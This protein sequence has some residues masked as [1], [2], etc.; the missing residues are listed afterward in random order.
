MRGET[1][2]VELVVQRRRILDLETARTLVKVLVE[3][4]PP[5]PSPDDA[6]TPPGYT[7]ERKLG[8]GAGGVVWLARRA[9]SDRPVALKILKRRLG[10][11]KSARRAWRE[12]ELLEQVRAPGTPRLVDYGTI[13]DRFYITAEHVDGISIDAYCEQKSLGT[14]ERVELLARLCEAAAGLHDA[15]VI[16]RDLKPSNVLVT[17]AGVPVIIDLGIA[18]L[19]A[20]DVMETLTADGAPIGTPAFMAPEQAR[21]ERS[22]IGIRS[23]VWS[24]GAIGYLLLTG[25]TP[26]DL[27]DTTL[28]EAVRRVGDEPPSEPL[29]IEPALPKPLG[30]VLSKACAP[31]SKARY[32]SAG[33]LAADLRRWLEHEPVEAQVAGAWV[34]TTRWI[35]RHPILSTGSVCLA[36]VASTALGIWGTV[37][38]YTLQ[39]FT[40]ETDGAGTTAWIASRSGR[41]LTT[42]VS[43]ASRGVKA[44]RIPLG[45]TE[46]RWAALL[47]APGERGLA[48]DAL[49][50]IDPWHPE[51]SVWT[52][53]DPGPYPP[54]Q[55]IAYESPIDRENHAYTIKTIFVADVFSE[56]D[57]LEFVCLN[58]GHPNF[59]SCIRVFGITTDWR[60][61]ELW[62]AWL[63][64]HLDARW[65]DSAGVFIV[66][67]SH[68]RLDFLTAENSGS[69]V[70]THHAQ[71]VMTLEPKLGYISDRWI[72][73]PGGA[74]S[75]AVG[76][77]IVLEQPLTGQTREATNDDTMVYLR[78]QTPPS[79]RST[80]TQCRIVMTGM[81]GG[82]DYGTIASVYVDGQLNQLGGLARTD[83]AS[84]DPRFQQILGRVEFAE[85]PFFDPNP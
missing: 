15:G 28:Y 66:A 50:I 55:T 11:G 59:P 24:L 21:G 47:V 78:P 33:E 36:I 7:L 25:R 51:E 45:W 80:D 19:L 22:A 18:S 37:R 52:C 16:H 70:S 67:G 82:R 65:L 63:P 38:H 32:G 46:A 85:A 69:A 84:L 4:T 20:S 31:A 6:T 9:G 77:C 60:V 41:P 62:R 68:N 54:L 23:D 30:A 49:Q 13:D 76:R 26:H 29:S 5:E 81:I 27:N 42:L 64:G 2:F 12:L 72:T 40:V 58:W 74:P 1:P 61:N 53:P 34:R 44:E 43:R 73:S 71:V 39:P 17:D 8:E 3:G 10:E 35:G 83:R 56:L 79:G 75:D 14:R 57:G 48:S